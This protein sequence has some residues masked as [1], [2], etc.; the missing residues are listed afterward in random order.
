M[1]DQT[2]EPPGGREAGG[3]PAD[4]SPSMPEPEPKTAASRPR[5]ARGSV[6]GAG[7][8]PT[9]GTDGQD[10]G[11]GKPPS[12]RLS[13][14]QPRPTWKA[15]TRAVPAPRSA[16]APSYSITVTALVGYPIAISF[17]AATSPS[18]SSSSCAR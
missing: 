14:R 5:S 8:L 17:E 1:Q 12:R 16:H 6:S 10:R 9:G 18:P 3:A 7:S 13:S 11:A 2:G 4:R 15:S